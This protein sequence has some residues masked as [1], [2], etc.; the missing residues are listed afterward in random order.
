VH[1]LPSAA[2]VVQRLVEEAVAALAQLVG[3][4]GP[5]R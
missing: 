5:R 3:S 2:D 1:D 4:E